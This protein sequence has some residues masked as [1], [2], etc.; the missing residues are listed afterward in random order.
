[1]QALHL[2]SFQL[3]MVAREA[4]IRARTDAAARPGSLP[5]ESILA[6]VMSAAATEAFVNEFAEHTPRLYSGLAPQLAP[7]N[8]TVCVQVL[9]DLEDSR[10]PVT[11]KYL[12]ATQLLGK[13]FD[14]GTAPFQD[15][16]DLVELRNAI[17]RIRPR[18]NGG[19][20]HGQRITDALAQRK[21]AISDSGDRALPWFDRL[22]T[23]AVAA[24]AHTAALEMIRAFLELVPALYESLN[25]RQ[26][27]AD[28]RYPA[29]L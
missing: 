1:M 8:L 21:L 3:L 15:F 5:S 11:T 22:M 27:I 25:N 10:M 12:V 26:S 19:P 2:R 17:M 14:A 16:K 6:I 4:V 23:P 13:S 20:H 28:A 24:W 29:I 7:A 18:F 9:Q